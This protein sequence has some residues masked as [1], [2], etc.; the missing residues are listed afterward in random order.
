MK[1]ALLLLI[2][3]LTASGAFGGDIKSGEDLIAAMHKR[4]DGKWYKTLTFKQITTNYKP[5]G[6]PEVETWYEALRAPG[7]LR[8]DIEPLEK[9]EGI[10]FT[11]GKVYSFKNGKLAGSRDF[12]HPLLV[13]GFDVYVQP[14]DATIAQ[15]KGMG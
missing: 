4:Y 10:L 7:S 11:G 1:T 2:V 3:G 8:I 15:I 5:D 13:L 9:H 14:V 12:T 6:T